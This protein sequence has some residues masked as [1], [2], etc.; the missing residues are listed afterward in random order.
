M[1][2]NGHKN[3]THWN[4]SLWLFNDEEYYNAMKH[5]VRFADTLD[6]AAR[7]LLEGLVDHCGIT[8]TP[9]GA[10]YT[11]TSVRAAL[12]HWDS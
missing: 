2:Y 3:W 7:G 11:F 9:D 10:R 1:T 6:D 8:H 5:A 4:V 12:A